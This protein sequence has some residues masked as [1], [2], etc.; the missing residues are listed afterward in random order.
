MSGP[1][2]NC[3]TC[4]GEGYE[5]IIEEGRCR[6]RVCGCAGACELCEGR[7]RR[8]VLDV[9]DGEQRMAR[10]RCQVVPDRIHLFDGIG[11]P[12]IY[13]G[14]SFMTFDPTR[15][16][17]RPGWVAATTWVEQYRPGDH[18][19]GLVLHG[20]VGRG[21]THLLAAI[22]REM[23]FRYGVRSRFLEFSELLTTL[24]TYFDAGKG[25]QAHLGGLVGV[26]VLGIDEL[27]KGRNSDWERQVIDELISRRYSGMF[28][29]LATTNYEPK[30]GTG[31]R[32][33][34]N[35]AV[36]ER[37]T[38]EDRV[39]ARVYSRLKQ[40]CNFAPVLGEDQRIVG[41]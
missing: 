37:E 3:T 40:M 2:E 20:D 13:K 39:G 4:R 18:N 19:R 7:G 29:T 14:A 6:A 38:L 27:G 25:A 16:G 8:L 11:L 5:V 36:V 15:P 33:R 31:R 24:K 17:A 21:K 1:D 35:L 9:A 10:C 26:E 34:H 30:Q 41:G 23:A 12:A 28:T 32:D 22:L